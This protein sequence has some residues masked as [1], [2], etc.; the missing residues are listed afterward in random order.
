[1][2]RWGPMGTRMQGPCEGASC[3]SKK[4]LKVAVSLS[5]FPLC[6]PSCAPPPPPH[7]LLPMSLSMSWF[8]DSILPK[9]F[10][11]W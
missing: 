6:I 2:L 5:F 3:A 10:S 9:W 7:P 11:E 1:M 4:W 8:F